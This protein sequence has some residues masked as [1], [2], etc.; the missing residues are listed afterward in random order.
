MKPLLFLLTAVLKVAFIGDP[1]ADSPVE[2]EYARQALREVR[3][4]KD[5]DLVVVLGDLV[6]D[7]PELQS[8]LKA[9][10]DSLPCRWICAPGNH[11]RDVYHEKGRKRDKVTFRKTMGYTDT[12]FVLKG[13]RFISLDDVREG[14]DGYKAGLREDQK[15][16][17]ASVMAKTPANMRTVV[18]CHIPLSEFQAK[19]SLAA[20]FRGH[21]RLLAVCGHTHTAGRSTLVLSDD[22]SFEQVIAGA[23]CGSWWRGPKGG[24]GLPY[25]LMNCGAPRGWFIAEFTGRKDWYGLEYRCT[26]RDPGDV[27]SVRLRDGMLM[28]NVYG[29]STEGKMF[30][31]SGKE[32]V[33][34]PRRAIPAAEAMEVYEWNR[35]QD[36]KLKKEHKELF[37]PILRMKSPHVWAAEC[38]GTALGGIALE[39]AVIEYADKA[40]TIRR[41][42]CF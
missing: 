37:I 9:S 3:E 10:L 24:D 16:W 8:S 31:V 36:K 22:V 17:L 21:K 40:M 2:V 30:L 20:I 6:N 33:E 32:R 42:I 1:Q 5:L 14:P 34:I 7:K 18:S 25:S 35:R 15:E 19:D 11:D 26:G 23:L 38:D 12:T 13:V 27:M 28:V 39:G 41:R 4:L 29:G